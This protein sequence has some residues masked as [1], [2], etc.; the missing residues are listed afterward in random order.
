MYLRYFLLAWILA[1]SHESSAS[2]FSSIDN[3][4][5]IPITVL[6][7]FLGSGKTTLLQHLLE[8]KEGLKI[9][10]VVNDV[11]TLNV[12]SRLISAKSSSD[13][14]VELQNGCACCSQSD[15]LL[16]SLAELVTL[17]DL[18][19][20]DEKFDH[21]VVE[22]SGVADPRVVR[23]KWQDAQYYRM[24]LTERLCLDTLVTVADTSTFLDYMS[25]S[26]GASLEESPELFN[27]GSAEEDVETDLDLIASG[28]WD[29]LQG[30]SEEPERE[31]SVAGLLA[32]QVETSD[33][34]LLNK[35][36][37]VGESSRE[38]S[39][40]RDIVAALGVRAKV[41]TTEYGRIDSHKILAAA[42]GQ[43][44]VLSG[45]VDDHQDAVEKAV[46]SKGMNSNLLPEKTN[47]HDH[48]H[49]DNG[50]DHQNHSH[51]HSHSRDHGEENAS[52]S[53]SHDHS[54]TADDSSH[55]VHSHA[56]EHASCTDPDCDDPGHSHSHDHQETIL[57]GGIG[58][59]V[60][61]ARRPFHP[62]RL[63]AFLKLLHIKWGLGDN[64]HAE[65]LEVS[66]EAESILAKDVVRSKG[67]CWLANSNNVATYWSH[68]GKSFELNVFGSWWATLPR[69][70]WPP[71]AVDTILKDFDNPNHE[72]NKD[73][74]SVGDRRQAVVFIGP[75]LDS[76]SSQ[77]TVAS[78]LNQ[79]LL[80][81]EEWKK[82]KENRFESE[83]LSKLFINQIEASP[84]NL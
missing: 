14:I 11:A 35:V 40:I 39:Q 22:L 78:A 7:G 16:A 47:S 56:H 74:E 83:A 75:G 4:R 9:A 71:D 51:S 59:F 33:I 45:L 41:H 46:E 20:D 26:K 52:H 81:D 68:A 62:Q 21:I 67:F 53:H 23:S 58:S 72:E 76:V 18:R 77:E 60:Y 36:D 64:S 5:P 48:E 34:I 2:A 28:L 12:D 10:V 42:K 31:I 54:G 50:H 66:Q 70:R 3:P 27:K 61:Q 44:V 15:E 73:S 19:A 38:V 84:V 17:S 25:S 63:M 32:A 29:T 1:A 24:P 79:C 65:S 43:G 8:N 69:D 6:S 55:D 49:S 80:D 57:P 82:F 13:G 30:S 37:L